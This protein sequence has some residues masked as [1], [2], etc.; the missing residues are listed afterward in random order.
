MTPLL[1][2]SFAGFA[3]Y[4]IARTGG[5]RIVAFMTSYREGFATVEEAA[6]AV[7]AFYPERP[8]PGDVS[9]LRKNL[10][11]HADGRLYWHWDPDLFGS[12]APPEMPDF[13]AWAA[14]MAPYIRAPVLLV[15]GSLSDVVDDRGTS[16]LRRLL[17]QTEVVT[18]DHA[19]HMLVGD[20]NDLFVVAVRA[21]LERHLPLRSA[22]L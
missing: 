19:G 9:G 22:G 7:S 13:G 6:D 3:R 12:G 21:F 8:R 15:R 18:V 14:G 17:P 5:E 4:L 1:C 16:D 2:P 11:E 20:S 10:R